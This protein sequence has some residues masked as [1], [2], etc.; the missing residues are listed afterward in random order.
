MELSIF[1]KPSGYFGY[2]HDDGN[3]HLGSFEAK[4]RPFMGLSGGIDRHFVSWL[5]GFQATDMEIS[6]HGI[7]LHLSHDE[8]QKND[9]VTIMALSCPSHSYTTRS[10]GFGL[11]MIWITL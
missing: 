7:C 5:L 3:L 10:F 9:H 11:K 6:P 8:F 2:P 4:F 1:F